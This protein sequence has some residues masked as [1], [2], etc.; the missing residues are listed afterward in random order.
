MKVQRKE[1]LFLQAYEIIKNDILTG[2]LRPGDRLLEVQIA[3]ELDVSRN[4][5]REAFRLLTQEGLINVDNNGHI[6][7]PMTPDDMK[8]IYE[9]R[10]M[11]EPFAASLAAQR[12]APE[13]IHDL[14]R[15]IDAAKDY[16][17]AGDLDGVI[18]TNTIFHNSIIKAC[19]NKLIYNIYANIQNLAIITR[20]MEMKNYKRPIGY[21]EEHREI[22]SLLASR[23]T[24]K[25]QSI[26]KYHIEGDWKYLNNALDEKKNGLITA[27]QNKS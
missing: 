5:V 1:P 4:P 8:E 13:N 12:I 10:M 27:A 7:R 11:V 20:T 18:K 15:N 6:V 25:V 17:E 26:M 2:V 3:N 24:K 9:C 21:L 14:Y 23:E 16:F 19:E 22:V